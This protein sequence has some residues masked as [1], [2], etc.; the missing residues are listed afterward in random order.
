MYSLWME[1]DEQI[2]M[3]FNQQVCYF[4][5]AV[6]ETCQNTGQFMFVLCVM[7]AASYQA[8]GQSEQVDPTAN[9]IWFDQIIGIENAGIINGPQYRMEMFSSSTHP[10]L[11]QSQVKGKVVYN[12]SIFYAPLLY[13]IYKDEVVVQHLSATGNAW[14]VQLDKT[15]V[16]EFTMD[17]RLFRKFDGGFQEV[18]F[19]SGDMLLVANHSKVGHV[20]NRLFKYVQVEQF[21]MITHGSSRPLKGPAAF[22]RMLPAKEDRRR[23]KQFLKHSNIKMRKFRHE[24]LVKVAAFVYPLWHKG[25]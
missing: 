9:E 16:S 7:M 6:I 12:G 20:R 11:I 15:Q 4:L 18:L 21:F 10:F 1:G 13:D 8:E 25:Q 14:F 23:V 17:T 5:N 2:S 24:D 22:Q 3:G 19:D